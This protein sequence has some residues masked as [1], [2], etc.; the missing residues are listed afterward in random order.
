MATIDQTLTIQ[1]RPEVVFDLLTDPEKAVVWQSSLLEAKLEPEGPM[2][3]GTR[4]SEVRKILGRSWESTVEV[5]QLEPER[6]FAG[7]VTSGPV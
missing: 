2:R 4:I 1:A 5:T 7:R 6:R 3:Q